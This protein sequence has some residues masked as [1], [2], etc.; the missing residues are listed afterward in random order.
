VK[1]VLSLQSPRDGDPSLDN[2]TISKKGSGT[3]LGLTSKRSLPSVKDNQPF[4]AREPTGS[5][6]GL[7]HAQNETWV[8]RFSDRKVAT[9]EDVFKTM[10]ALPSHA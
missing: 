5:S 6:N 3:N 9:G 1:G 8:L 10:M 2:V 7:D 4:Q